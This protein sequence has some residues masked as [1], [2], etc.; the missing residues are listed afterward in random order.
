MDE[1][2]TL[3]RQR[4][5][6]LTSDIIM[7]K[8]MLDLTKFHIAGQRASHLKQL[9]CLQE[10]HERVKSNIAMLEQPANAHDPSD[11][12]R[13]DSSSQARTF[14]QLLDQEEPDSKYHAFHEEW[15]SFNNQ[16]FVFNPVAVLISKTR[17][18]L[19]QYYN[20]TQ[21]H[22]SFLQRLSIVEQR[23]IHALLERARMYI[24][25]Q[26]PSGDMEDASTLLDDVIVD[27]TRLA[28]ANLPDTFLND[29]GADSSSEYRPNDGISD[30]FLLRKKTICLCVQP[31]VIFHSRIGENST[32]IFH[33]DQ[34]RLRN[35]AL[36]DSMYDE[37]S[38]N[39]NVLHRNFISMRSLQVFH[40][41]RA[42]HFNP[43]SYNTLESLQLPVEA[44]NG[45]RE[46]GY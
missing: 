38:I 3:E 39:H 46:P 36:S 4:L 30:E 32:L 27:T 5:G 9:A 37:R 24:D 25:Q 40:T 26:A 8:S 17:D 33:A 31:E 34:M 22:R 43:E 12:G 10:A 1:Q 19:L 35:Y 7:L 2:L 15:D 13:A 20:N 41:E 21:L 23:Q 6:H 28:C 16:V 14:H 18:V 42:I 29:F 45:Q 44:L 11:D